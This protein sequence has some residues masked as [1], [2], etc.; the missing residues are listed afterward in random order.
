MRFDPA[1]LAALSAKTVHALPFAAVAD[2]LPAG[3][4]EA[5]WDAVRG[6]CATVADAAGWWAAITGPVAAALPAEDRAFVA[7]ARAALATLPWGLGVW[8]DWTAALKAATGRKGRALFHP[9]RLA[10]TGRDHGPEMAALLP[11]IGRDAALARLELAAA[12]D[13]ISGQE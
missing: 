12:G 6:N 5:A 4:T 11:L 2:R 8:A 3:M 7:A 1:D 9:L 10:L 13:Y